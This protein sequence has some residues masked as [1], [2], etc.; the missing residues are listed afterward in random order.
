[1][2]PRAADV[3]EIDR[4][5]TAEAVELL[6]LAFADD[7]GY[8]HFTAA[9][10]EKMRRRMRV[11]FRE[12]VAMQEA[13]GQP[14]LGILPGGRLAAVAVV[15]EPGAHFPWP[16]KLR[17]L[18]AVAIKV[19]P[20]T[21]WRT[22]RNLTAT[23]RHH[24]ATPHYYLP[25]LGVHPDYRGQG[26]GGALLEALHARSEANAVSTGVCLETENPN[27][28]ALYKHFGYRVTHRFNVG[29]LGVTVMFRPDGTP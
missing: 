21:T 18:L 20:V 4:T 19:S 13:A 2:K 24:P 7:P 8:R 29:G 5:R 17:W 9:T 28:V 12:G 23:A 11:W 10:G 27:N 22:F 25:V 16:A 15:Q 6:V 14:V 3:I 1:M 26:Y